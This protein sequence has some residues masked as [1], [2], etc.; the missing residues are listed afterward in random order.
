MTVEI[1]TGDSAYGPTTTIVATVSGAAKSITW[2]G[3]THPALVDSA[4]RSLAAQMDLGADAVA[5]LEF[6]VAELLA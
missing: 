5:E 4:V 1:K 3:G 6:R 2:T